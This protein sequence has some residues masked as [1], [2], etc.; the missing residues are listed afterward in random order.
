[1]LSRKNKVDRYLSHHNLVNGDHVDITPEDPSFKYRLT[2]GISIQYKFPL[3]HSWS[4][5]M[6]VMYAR[7]FSKFGRNQMLNLN[8]SICKSIR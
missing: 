3:A 5:E 4:T 7:D 6:G 8:L 2:P 1:M